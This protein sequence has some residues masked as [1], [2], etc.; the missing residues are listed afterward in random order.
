MPE[1]TRRHR[2]M[3]RWGLITTGLVIVLSLIVW[4]LTGP[5]DPYSSD[6]DPT[7]GV[8][9]ALERQASAEMAGFRFEAVSDIAG[10]DFDHFPAIRQSLLPEDMG[11]GAAWGDYDNDGDPDLFLVNFRGNLV[12]GGD[13]RCALYRNNGDGTFSDIS[14]EAGV[15]IAINGLGASW[16]DYD[17]DG[18]LDLYISAYGENVLLRNNAGRGFSDVTAQA[19]VGDPGFGAGVAW[20]DYNGNGWL[21]L[22][23]TNYVEFD[24]RPE[25]LDRTDQ[26]YDTEVPYTLNP[27]SYSPAAN[28]FYRNNGDG[29]FTE[30]AT[31]AGVANPDGRSLQPV[32]FDFDND[33][34]LDLYVANDVSSNAVFHN[35]PE[36]LLDIGASSLAADYRGA[37]GLAVGDYNSDGLLDLFITHWVAQENVLF[38]NMTRL[39]TAQT[40]RVLFMEVGEMLGLGYSS[41]RQVGWATGFADFDND[42]QLDLWAA[43]GHT[44]QDRNDP[45]RLIAQPLLLYRNVGQRGYVDVT[46]YAWPDARPLVARGGA[47]ADY[48]GDGRLDL[49]IMIHGSQ[50]VLLRNI[51]EPIGHWITLR[52]RQKHRNTHAVGA[53][54]QLRT[55][56][57]VQTAQVLAGDSYLSQHHG[58]LHFGLGTHDRIDEIIIDWPDGQRQVLT[59]LPGNER[60]TLT[61]TPDY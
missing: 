59:D 52:L 30:I 11:S 32:W 40:P 29:T 7:R 56:P 55:G 37:M 19:G 15:D 60:L 27:S 6:D 31:Q 49:V 16:G 8:T 41:L 46:E 42:G 17:N 13:G 50:P 34:R 12:T 48:D 2:L 51:T 54:V 36:G 44:L 5:V 22:Y 26:Q 21:D 20:A 47:Q 43:N 38:E 23:V 4:Q 24:Y 39:D 28:R 57:K 1:L 45:S 14:A 9:H 18:F 61:H 35:R 10:I 33:G 58:D 3:L 53:R 25:D